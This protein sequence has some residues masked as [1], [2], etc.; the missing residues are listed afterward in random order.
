[1]EA[2]IETECDYCAKPI[3]IGQCMWKKAWLSA[4]ESEELRRIRE[5]R[6]N[7]HSDL[8]TTAS[9]NRKAKFNSF[10][11]R[12]NLYSRCTAQPYIKESQFAFWVFSSIQN[13]K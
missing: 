9:L 5:N 8:S 1:M 10:I 6:S 11:H 4:C 2:R 7:S 12:G 3:T 13:E